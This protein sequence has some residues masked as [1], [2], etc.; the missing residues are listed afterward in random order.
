MNQARQIQLPRALKGGKNALSKA[1][2][3]E[4]M[5]LSRRRPG[6]FL[7]H[8]LLTW[9]VIFG[10]ISLAV[11]ADNLLVSLLVIFVIATR[12]N[13][14]GLL[15]HDQAHCLGFKARFGDVIT[16]II[17]AYPLLVL[18]VEGYSKVHLSHHRHF[19]TRDDPD[20]LRKSGEEWHFPKKKSNLGKL[21][22]RDLLGLNLWAL[23]KGKKLD[24]PVFKRPHPT[25]GWVRPTFYILVAVLLTLTGTWHLFLIYWVLPLLTFT[26]VFVRWGAMSE[27]I[28]NLPDASTEESSPIIARKW[29]G[30]LILPNLNFTLHPYHHYFPGVPFSNLQ[31]VH[32]IFIREGLVEEA[33]VFH[34]YW[35]Y[36]RFLTTCVDE[37]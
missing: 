5:N 6:M 12:Q 23:I 8:A 7:F 18:T 37:P 3:R 30:H 33:N 21:F 19:F 36:L 9:A 24:V 1:A 26:Q 29:W 15:V 16:N 17:A 34:S 10:S 32:E 11:W 25:P 31:K 35:Q 22:L 27:H 4:I 14:L 13:V 28:Y 20:F 2:R